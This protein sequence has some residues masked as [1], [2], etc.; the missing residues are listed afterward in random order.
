MRP[1]V[2]KY[3]IDMAYLVA[4]RSTCIRRS[5]GC[6]LVDIRNHVLATGYNG[7]P[8]G[9][10]HCNE[11][12]PCPGAKAPSGTML[13]AC[14]AIHAEQNALLQC[15]DTNLIHRAYVTAFPCTTCAKLLLNTSCASIVYWE[16]YADK[17]GM[18]LWTESGR[19]ARN[20]SL[21]QKL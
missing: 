20:L 3:F 6:V 11:D 5:V 13:D 21:D 14:Y 16:V 7:V 19:S 8:R 12:A 2:D 9:F 4:S 15:R 17:I 1:N 18:K 10:D